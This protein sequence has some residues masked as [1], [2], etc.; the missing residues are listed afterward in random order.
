MDGLDVD[1][2][3]M[4][5]QTPSI[6]GLMQRINGAG[7]LE[8]LS[9]LVAPL[10]PDTTLLLYHLLQVAAWALEAGLAAY[11][12]LQAENKVETA[13]KEGAVVGGGLAGAWVGSKI[14][15]ACGPLAWAC[16]PILGLIGGFA[17]GEAGDWAVDT[18]KGW[19]PEAGPE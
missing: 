2:L 13:A 6:A 1:W 5:G 8:T 16:S 11:E 10:A 14:G 3:M 18:V 19:F 7:S 9:K 12:V 17:G 15:L 4:I